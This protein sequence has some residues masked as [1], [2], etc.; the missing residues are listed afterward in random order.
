MET[1]LKSD[2]KRAQTGSVAGE[3]TPARTIF[4]FITEGFRVRILYGDVLALFRKQFR[5]VILVPP[6][7]VAAIERVFGSENVIVK[8]IP[9]V[10]TRWEAGLA[11]VRRYLLSNPARN[12]TNSIFYSVIKRQQPFRYA[13]IRYVNPWLGRSRILRDLWLAVETKL[14]RGNEYGDL[15][16]T[17]QP[18]LVLT[19]D[20]GTQQQEIRILRHA[21][22]RGVKTASV[23]NS[24]DNLVSKGVMGCRPGKLIVWNE[25]MR[26]EAAA[27]HDMEPG[28][29]YACGP[30]HFDVYAHHEKFRTREEFCRDMKL[31]PDRPIIV[32]GTI[33]PKYFP[34]NIEI[35]EIIATAITEGRLPKNCQIIVRLHPQ[36][37]NEGLYADNLTDYE[38]V[39]RRH[40][41]IRIDVPQTMRWGSMV[42]PH[43][44]D[45]KHL[46]EVLH[47]A[48]V[49]VHPGSTLVVDASA[50]DCPAVGLGFDGYRPK[51]YDESIRRWWDYTY[52]LPIVRSGGQP[53]ARSEGELIEAIGQF[54][55]DR[56]H[57]AAGRR[58][59]RD[60]ECYKVDGGA[61]QRIVR[62]MLDYIG[63]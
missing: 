34:E 28:D 31:D 51:P 37:V 56:H 29:V 41:F 59:I 20:Y 42:S 7:D 19:T 55:N 58:E 12:R 2:P 8:P 61:S 17:Y 40:P 44:A 46:A 26:E 21:Q 47:H 33:T 36:V 48:A 30:A 24:W 1:N 43:P 14:N 45:A 52:M 53:I 60:L 57:L 27:L 6:P 11:F 50:V 39:A 38:A 3:G 54:L 23:V 15:F 4:I 18:S 16:D 25:I 49:L 10:R 22:G 5:V 63:K 35:L 13:V 9:G 62:A 32:Q